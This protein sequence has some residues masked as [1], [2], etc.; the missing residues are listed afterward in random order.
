MPE[1]IADPPSFCCFR[2]FLAPGIDESQRLGPDL[3][4]VTRGAGARR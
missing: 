1:I 4:C 3:F 2:L